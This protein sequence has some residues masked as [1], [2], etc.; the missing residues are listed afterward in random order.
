MT[1]KSTMPTSFVFRVLLFKEGDHWVAQGLEYDVAAQGRSREETKAAFQR[2]FIGR[3]L[4]DVERGREPLKGV[5]RA[6]AQ[7]WKVFAELTEHEK[8]LSAPERIVSPEQSP[9]GI[10]V[11]PAFM[12][13]IIQQDSHTH[14]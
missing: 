9:A 2:T 8:T 5:E 7:Y 6:P 12:I 1:R 10:D 3:L 14:S 13:S 4:F 11:P